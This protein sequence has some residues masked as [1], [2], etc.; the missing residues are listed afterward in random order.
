MKSDMTKN[1][2]YLECDCEMPNHLMVFELYE[3]EEHS[4]ISVYF[5]SD[6]RQSFFKRLRMCFDLLFKKQPFMWTDAVMVNS[7]NIHQLKDIVDYIEKMD[8]IK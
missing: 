8:M 3:D 2:F 7:K 6:W 5:A 1:R 4:E